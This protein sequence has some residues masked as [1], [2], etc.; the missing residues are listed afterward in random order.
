MISLKFLLLFS[1]STHEQC[2]FTTTSDLSGSQSCCLLCGIL[3][4][5][6][7]CPSGLSYPLGLM[8]WASSWDL[9][10]LQSWDGAV[11]S[12]TLCC[13]DLGFLPSVVTVSGSVWE[14]ALL[15]SCIRKK[16]SH[17][18]NYLFPLSSVVLRIFLFMLL[19]FLTCLMI[20]G[21]PFIF[22][23]EALGNDYFR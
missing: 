10:S 13:P 4:F 21:C 22:K 20:F 23:T 6:W 2:A 12:C 17:F 3:H 19:G 8:N 1:L 14:V 16:F 9:S 11:V 7:S 15:S 18:L 5:S